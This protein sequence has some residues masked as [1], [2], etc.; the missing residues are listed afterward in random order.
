MNKEDDDTRWLPIYLTA[1][2]WDCPPPWKYSEDEPTHYS[3]EPMYGF[4]SVVEERYNDHGI[5]PFWNLGLA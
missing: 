2:H 5:A 4:S 3:V 1:Q